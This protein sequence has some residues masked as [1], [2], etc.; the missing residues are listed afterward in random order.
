MLDPQWIGR[1]ADAV[2]RHRLDM[3]LGKDGEEDA[4]GEVDGSDD[5]EAAEFYL[6][7]LALLDQAHRT[8][9]LAALKQT[10]AVA[11]SQGGPR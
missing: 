6:M 5:D 3:L 8:L 10:R 2:Q 11:L 1:Q 4:C 9:R 7:A